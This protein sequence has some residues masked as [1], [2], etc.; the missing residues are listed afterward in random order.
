MKLALQALK[1]LKQQAEWDLPRPTLPE[2]PEDLLYLYDLLEASPRQEDLRRLLTDGHRVRVLDNF[3]TGRRSRLE[4]IGGDFE[5]LEGDLRNV[6]D[7]QAACQDVEI[8]FHE[9]ALPSV[10]GG[11]PGPP[12]PEGPSAHRIL[13]HDMQFTSSV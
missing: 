11:A 7:C 2:D 12:G 4:N 13:L 9:A 3:S 6:E 8:I 5:C 10:P 1:L